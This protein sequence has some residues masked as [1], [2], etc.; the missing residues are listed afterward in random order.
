MGLFDMT[1]GSLIPVVSTSFA[2]EGVLERTHLQAALRD[3]VSLLGEDLL[4]VAEEFGDFSDANRRIDLLCIDREARP[5]VVELKR[6]NDGGHMEL[7]ALRYAAMVSAMTFDDL[8]NIYRA[9][10]S[11]SADAVTDPAESLSN[12]LDDVGGAEAVVRRDVRLIL[13]AA[14][15]GKEI[16]TTALWLNDVFGMDIRCVRM[17]PYRVHGR[18]LLNVEQVIPL[19][20]A[21]DI[22]IKLRRREAAA[23]VVT[24]SSA[25]WTP[26]IVTTPAGPTS[27][28]RKRRAVLAM[29]HAVHAAGANADRIASVLGVR[30]LGVDGVLDGEALVDAFVA[31]HPK[32]EHHTG[33]WFLDDPIHEDSSTWVL[34]KMWGTNTEAAL[35]ALSQLVPD[36]GIVF[37]PA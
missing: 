25:D 15:F 21:E 17:T 14:D 33:R 5:V 20:E 23:R 16:T 4:V 6:T 19:P 8:L 24:A 13:A 11:R 26:Y 22:T 9:H 2:A 32:A 12:W 10:L 18:L 7:Q 34:S 1:D 36:S 29:V 28:L 35:T 27:P 3:N 31:S 30:F 37:A